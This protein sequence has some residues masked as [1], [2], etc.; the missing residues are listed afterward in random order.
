MTR[1]HNMPV[2]EGARAL[3]EAGVL[4]AV[5]RA[6]FKPMMW[7]EEVELELDFE[8]PAGLRTFRIMCGE[9]GANDVHVAEGTVLELFYGHL[10]GEEPE[11]WAEAVAA[12]RL[13]PELDAEWAIGARLVRPVRLEMTKP[14]AE[15]V[16]FAFECERDG[17]SLGRL[18]MFASADILF[19]VREDHP[20]V[21]K[22]G[23]R[24]LS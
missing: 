14:Y 21:A 20:E 10:R 19:A 5:R 2:R 12:W 11:S 3:C 7:K 15:P 6:G 1:E 9:I 18:M 23:L 24:E 16:G 17:L 13:D 22:Y 4:R 8:G